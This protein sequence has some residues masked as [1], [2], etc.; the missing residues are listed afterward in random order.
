[1]KWG[2][3]MSDTMF[4]VFVAAAIFFLVLLPAFLGSVWYKHKNKKSD[5]AG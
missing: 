5:D 4:L 1:M 3:K 2:K